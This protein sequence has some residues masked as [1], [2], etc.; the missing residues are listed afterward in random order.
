MDKL[1]PMVLERFIQKLTLC[2]VMLNLKAQK[3]KVPKNPVKIPSQ[4]SD[5][6][7]TKSCVHLTFVT[8]FFQGFLWPKFFEFSINFDF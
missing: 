5:D 7:A 1:V 4:M 3:F 8:Q 6:K 2:H